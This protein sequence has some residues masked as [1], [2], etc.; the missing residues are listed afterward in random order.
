MP[1]NRMTSALLVCLVLVG[2]PVAAGELVPFY[3]DWDG[4]TVS[5]SP[6][7]DPTVVLVVSGGDGRATQLGLFKMVSPHYTDLATFTVQGTQ[8]FVAANGDGLDATIEGQFVPQ[9]DGSLHAVLTGAFTGGSGRFAGAS[10]TYEFHI[11]SRPIG[12]GGFAS[13]ARLIG[14]IST[15]G[16]H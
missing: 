2:R 6:T 13:T 8:H 9:A 14:T 1:R 11:T 16:G 15:V 3:G 5:A 7:D 12:T 10:G 4:V